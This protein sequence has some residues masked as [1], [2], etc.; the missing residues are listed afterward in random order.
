MPF[1]ELRP[2]GFQTNTKQNG[3]SLPPI[4]VKTLSTENKERILKSAIKKS[5]VRFKV[6]YI[7]ITKEFSTEILKARRAWNEVF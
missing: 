4:I 7:K 5:H 1:Q 6:K 3:T 2:P